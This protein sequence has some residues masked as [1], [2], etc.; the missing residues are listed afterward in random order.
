MIDDHD[1]KN[2]YLLIPSFYIVV[3][4]LMRSWVVCLVKTDLN[5][6][7]EYQISSNPIHNQN[8]QKLIDITLQ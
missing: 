7:I 4:Y 3:F 5:I 8:N 2:R 6:N 1:Q